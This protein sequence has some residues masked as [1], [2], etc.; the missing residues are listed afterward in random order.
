MINIGDHHTYANCIRRH[1]CKPPKITEIKLVIL[2]K[3]QNDKISDWYFKRR[4]KLSAR[5]FLFHVLWPSSVRLTEV[6]SHYKTLTIITITRPIVYYLQW[7]R[8]N[9]PCH[10]G[11]MSLALC[12]AR[13]F[14]LLHSYN[15]VTSLNMHYAAHS[16]SE[17]LIY[18]VVW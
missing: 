3:H 4:Q 17:E 1:Y 10:I 5:V 9:Y 13:A 14:V 7:A 16:T 15:E 6:M 12:Y 2:P 8:V 11:V 18:F